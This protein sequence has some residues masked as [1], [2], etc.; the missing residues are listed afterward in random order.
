[1]AQ[2]KQRTNEEI[3]KAALDDL[4]GFVHAINDLPEYN[5]KY[6]YERILRAVQEA[7]SK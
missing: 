5:H 3:A 6:I 2:P 4:K 1:M 7:R